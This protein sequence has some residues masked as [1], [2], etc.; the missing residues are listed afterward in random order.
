[1]EEEDDGVF[2]FDINPAAVATDL[3]RLVVVV[4]EEVTILAAAATPSFLIIFIFTF[5]DSSQTT[6]TS[7]S[8]S[9]SPRF[10][11]PTPPGLLSLPAHFCPTPFS[12]ADSP[13]LPFSPTKRNR[14]KAPPKV[15]FRCTPSTAPLECCSGFSEIPTDPSSVLTCA[16][17]VITFALFHFSEV[18]SS[19]EFF[20]PATSRGE[21]IDL[22]PSVI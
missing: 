17:T 4:L 1:M 12:P 13:P 16:S 3:L 7:T 11:F 5:F 20:N 8:T 22:M 18:V 9:T 2:F 14:S 19:P 10:L 21:I 15:K 6:S